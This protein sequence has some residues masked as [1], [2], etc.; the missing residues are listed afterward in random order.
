MVGYLFPARREE[1]LQKPRSSQRIPVKHRQR[2]RAHRKNGIIGRPPV[3]IITSYV[4]CIITAGLRT[5]D[6]H[7]AG[8]LDY[9]ARGIWIETAGPISTADNAAIGRVAEGFVCND[10]SLVDRRFKRAPAPGLLP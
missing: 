7:V 1:G 5:V 6:S 9:N 2:S 10:F 8:Q 4:L 3:L